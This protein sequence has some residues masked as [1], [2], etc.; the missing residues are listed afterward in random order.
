VSKL[1][2]AASFGLLLSFDIKSPVIDLSTF[3]ISL[4][5]AISPIYLIKIEIDKLLSY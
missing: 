4:N 1:S 3:G 2:K 5:L